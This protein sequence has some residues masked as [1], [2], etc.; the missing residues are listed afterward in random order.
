M[1]HKRNSAFS[2]YSEGNYHCTCTVQMFTLKPAF[3]FKLPNILLV[4]VVVF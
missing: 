1:E 2:I 3:F 4:V